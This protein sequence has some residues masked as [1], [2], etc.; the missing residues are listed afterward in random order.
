MAACPPREL[1]IRPAGTADLSAV[2]RLLAE[3]GDW[4]RS[5]GITDQWPSK[6]PISDLA[7]RADRG[8]LHIA[9][10]HGT[11]VGTFAVDYHALA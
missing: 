2:A 4:M 11:P 9:Y 6:F 10:D 3:A 5:Q 1:V 8:E 7:E